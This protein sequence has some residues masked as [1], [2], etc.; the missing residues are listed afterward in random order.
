M[1]ITKHG[2]NLVQ[3]TRFPL[4]F[5]VNVFLVRE[6]DGF[7]LI[8][9]SVGGSAPAILKA[10][11]VL[12][13]DIVRLTLTHAHN[14]HIGSLDALIAALPNAELSM[15]AE[16]ARVLN[17]AREA[18]ARKSPEK[19]LP[20]LRPRLLQPGDRVGSLEVIAAPGHSVDHIVFLDTRDRTLIVGDAFQTRGGT[21]VS[22]TVNWSFP[23][24]AFAT[25]DKAQALESAR[26]LRSLQPTRLAV[27]HGNALASPLN[28][29]DAAI[30][31]AERKLNKA[32][33]HA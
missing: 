27:G 5:P 15:S 33:V 18:K 16:T 7:T 4:L 9:A 8:D 26:A 14:D 30:R 22:G 24:P 21:A 17:E 10:A 1:K 19:V 23:F 11:K 28:A 6:D 13:G 31:V 2:E 32:T 12:G 25:A 3:L 20:A 29:M